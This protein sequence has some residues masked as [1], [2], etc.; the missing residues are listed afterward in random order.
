MK[1]N[2]FTL[3]ELICAIGIMAMLAT[4]LVP[5]VVKRINSAKE[6]S[7]ET[8]IESIELAAE[9]Y[10]IENGDS[11]VEYNQNDNIYIKIDTLIKNNYFDKSLINPKTKEALPSTDEVYVTRNS[12]GKIESIYDINQN[13]NPKI[14]LNGSYN[15]YV[16]KNQQFVDPGVVA[17]T[18][19]GTDVTNEIVVVGYVDTSI[20][21]TYVI[22]YMYEGKTIKRNVIV[23]EI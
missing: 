11:I 23:Y 17:T 13:I 20:T 1:K 5:I 9:S 2:G 22:E 16:K 18:P 7:Y 15:I 14:V 3:I 6:T 10:I 8:L 19:S 4:I 21:N 12:K